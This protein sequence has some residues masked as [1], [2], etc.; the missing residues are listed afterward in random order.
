MLV[1]DVICSKEERLSTVYITSHNGVL[2]D[3]LGVLYYKDYQGNVTKIL[4]DKVNEIVFL[5][6][7]TITSGAFY[8]LFRYNIDVVFLSTRGKYTS[9]LIY[10]D[11]KNTLLRHRQHIL[12]ENKEISLKIAK[13]IVRGKLHNQYYFM[14][15]IARKKGSDASIVHEA[16]CEIGVIRRRLETAKTIEE[17]RGYEGD[18][19]K[20]YFSVFGEN[21]TCDWTTFSG[22]SKN[23]P[24]DEVNAVLSLLYTVLAN[25]LVSYIHA[26]G[27]DSGI[28]TLHAL[29]YGRESL[30]FDLIEEFR[31][32]L[33]DALTCSLFNMGVLKKEHFRIEVHGEIGEENDKLVKGRQDAVLLNEEGFRKVLEQFER[34]MLET[35]F[36]E[37]SCSVLT[38]NQI[39]RQQVLLYKK[40]ITGLVDYYTPVLIK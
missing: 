19:S 5:G 18:G 2:N 38:Y 28:G 35:H 40:V 29:S 32:P 1:S 24:N 17:V 23:P 8:L 7:T 34:K 39:L 33:A 10:S 9:R 20:L 27:L 16:I 4:P 21:I 37:G 6:R 3:S 11:K 30:V 22:R 14:Q 31:T 13:D 25:R 15:R 12:S 26:S 36:Y